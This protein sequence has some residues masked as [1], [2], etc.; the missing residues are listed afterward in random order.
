MIGVAAPADQIDRVGEFFELF[1]TPWEPLVPGKRYPIVLI[2]DG[3]TEPGEAA[4]AGEAAVALVYG[5][6]EHPIDR[7]IEVTSQR[8]PGPVSVR[9]GDSTLPVYGAV[10]TFQGDIKGGVLSA[11]GN[12]VDYRATVGRVTVLR[13]GYDLFD[14]VAVLLSRGQPQRYAS[15]PTLEIHIA[16][17]REWLEETRVEYLEIPPCPDR[18]RFVC[19][20]THDIDFFGI[21]RHRADRTLAGFALRGTLGTALDLVRGHRPLDEAIRNWL[22][23]L[24]LP[25]VFFGLKRDPWDPLSDYAT[26]DRDHSSTFFLVPFRHQA[27]VTPEGTVESHRSVAYGIRDITADVQALATAR[28]E[29]GVHGIESW[30]AAAAGRAEMRELTAVTDQQRT[31]VRIHWLYFAEDSPRVLE[32][33]GFDYDSTWGYNDEIGFRAGT[34]QPFRFPGT[35]HLLELPL[36]IMDSAMFYRSRMGLTR[37]QARVRCSAIVEGARHFGGALV[38]NWHDRSLAP[39]RQWGRCYRTL[40]SDIEA[41][42]G[43]FAKAGEAVDW[44]RWRR[45]IRFS[46]DPSANEVVVEAP[47]VPHPLPAARLVVHGRAATAERAYAGGLCR[48]TLSGRPDVLLPA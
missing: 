39:E 29:C 20:L 37:E 7:R 38:V 26:A 43:W 31:G 3:H 6:G 35:V 14:E 10:A 36:A 42:G 24:S 46:G 8:S 12:A 13:V 22:A 16:L 15:T 47:A 28:F 27:G 19:C 32:D 21:R 34:L 48:L 45:S 40:L 30:R 1:K 2:A 44:F 23:V 41:S 9:W 18:A 11:D 25:A 33:A 4:L 5:A 17:I